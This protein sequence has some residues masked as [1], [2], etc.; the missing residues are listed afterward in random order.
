MLHAAL[1]GNRVWPRII[2]N[3]A[4][5]DARI[6]AVEPPDYRVESECDAVAVG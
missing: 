6:W 1:G 3:V 2:D 4:D 5:C